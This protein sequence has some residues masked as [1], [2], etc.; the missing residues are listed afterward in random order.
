MLAVSHVPGGREIARAQRTERRDV[1]RVL[2]LETSGGI[3]PPRG[4]QGEALL[5]EAVCPDHITAEYGRGDQRVQGAALQDARPA[6]QRAASECGLRAGHRGC[7]EAA[8]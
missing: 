7:A 4:Q 1:Q 2:E 3:I 5:G 8:A 6:R